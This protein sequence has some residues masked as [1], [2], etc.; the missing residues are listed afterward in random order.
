MSGSKSSKYH[1]TG[2]IGCYFIL[3]SVWTSWIKCGELL[4]SQDSCL[5]WRQTCFSLPRNLAI[6]YMYMPRRGFICCLTFDE[7]I[8][9]GIFSKFLI[10][11]YLLNYQADVHQTF[12]DKV[13]LGYC[14]LHFLLAKLW[15][16]S[17]FLFLVTN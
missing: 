3:A 9:Y 14:T 6:M 2:T 17:N 8:G 4:L 13:T 12:A 1:L 16:L 7:D 15:P 10:C 11:H 5:S